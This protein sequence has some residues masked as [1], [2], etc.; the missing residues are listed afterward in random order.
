M[1]PQLTIPAVRAGAEIPIRIQAPGAHRAVVYLIDTGISRTHHP[2]PDPAAWFD[3]KR[4][5]NGMSI[6]SSKRVMLGQQFIPEGSG[7]HDSTD[8]AFV[9][10]RAAPQQAR[11]LTYFNP[12][13]QFRPKRE[14]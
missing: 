2:A 3:L 14:W 9:S 11:G 12:R 8:L 10:Q 5:A 1:H 6:A 7:I 13:T 4:R